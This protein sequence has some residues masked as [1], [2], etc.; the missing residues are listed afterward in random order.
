[1]R[2]LKRF[3]LPLI[4]GVVVGLLVAAAVWAKLTQNSLPTVTLRSSTVTADIKDTTLQLSFDILTEDQPRVEEFSQHMRVPS[5]WSQGMQLVLD[6]P[7]AEAL[8]HF[9]PLKSSLKIEPY[10]LTFEPT[11]LKKIVGLQSATPGDL[12]SLASGSATLDVGTDEKGNMMIKT[13]NLGQALQQAI[14]AGST[15]FSP[16]FLQSIVPIAD[17][18]ESAEFLVMPG[19]AKGFIQLEQ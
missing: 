1:M 13:Q 5:S 9:M 8:K 2:Y 10:R 6:R 11:G 14:A 4:I 17:T 12:I 7:S 3:K 18:I 19:S 16:T 15:Q